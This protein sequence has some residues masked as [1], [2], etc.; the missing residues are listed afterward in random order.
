MKKCARPLDAVTRQIWQV[1]VADLNLNE[2]RR[3]RKWRL[4]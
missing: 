2:L 1:T 4:W 3:R